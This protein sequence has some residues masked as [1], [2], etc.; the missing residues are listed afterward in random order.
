MTACP[1]CGLVNPETAK[2]CDC[3]YDFDRGRVISESPAAKQWASD[4]ALSKERNFFLLGFFTLVGVNLSFRL[5]SVLAA[6]ET[7][8][9]LLGLGVILTLFFKGIFIY[10]VFRLSRYLRQPLWLT[11]LFCVLAPFSLLYLIPFVGVLI[12]V[13]NA[14]RSLHSGA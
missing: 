12:G 2:L 8:E 11:I 9:D 10:L 13:R 14:R 7:Q 3:G 4:R 6:A 1:H 5:I